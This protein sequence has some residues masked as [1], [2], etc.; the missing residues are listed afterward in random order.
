MVKFKKKKE[1]EEEKG[2]LHGCTL[3]PGSCTHWT[4]SQSFVRGWLSSALQDKRWRSRSGGGKGQE[5]DVSYYMCR[6]DTEV[7][8]AFVKGLLN[9]SVAS[10]FPVIF[11]WDAPW[12]TK[13]I[14]CNWWRN[15]AKRLSSKKKRKKKGINK[16]NLCNWIW[17]LTIVLADS[18]RRKCL[19]TVI[20]ESHF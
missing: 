8:W 14:S 5:R 20:T 9:L 4:T 19:F 3:F 17:S 18:S 1:R 6:A 7:W 13:T 10:D 16:K 15:G 2:I 11:G 12:F